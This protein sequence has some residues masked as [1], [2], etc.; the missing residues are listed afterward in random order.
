M[1]RVLIIDD[2]CFK[3]Q[4]SIRTSFESSDVLLVLCNTKDKGLELIKSR[5]LFDCIVLDWYLE[6]EDSTLS[7]LILKELEKKYYTPVLIYSAHSEIFLEEKATGG[8]T[9]PENLIKVIQKNDYSEIKGKVE[10]W[11]STNYTARLSNLYLEKVYEHIHKTFWDLNEIP[12]GNIALLYKKVIFENGNI[13]WSNDFIINLLLQKVISDELFRSSITN[14]IDKLGTTEINADTNNKKIIISKLL[15]H[16]SNPVCLQN[17]DIVQLSYDSNSIFGIIL[18]PDCDLSQNNTAYI[19][20]LELVKF[21]EKVLA[22][23]NETISLNKSGNHFYLPSIKF[24]STLID[25]V[26]VFKAPLFLCAKE[27]FADKY[28]MVNKRLKYSDN[29]TL[30]GKDCEIKYICSLNNPYKAEF[31]YKKSSHDN[32]VGIPDI[33]KYLNDN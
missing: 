32:R 9:Y 5:A 10:E 23:S 14:L 21:K 24:D 28:P 13:Q 16:Y 20:I 4:E 6:G 1:N 25:L 7:K 8:I 31:M 19:E 17:S 15:Y 11:L 27:N 18:T 22:N 33:Y 12:D 29:Y 30:S 3:E 2:D 26:A